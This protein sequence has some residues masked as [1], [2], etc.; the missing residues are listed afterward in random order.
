MGVDADET[1]LTCPAYPLSWA[2]SKSAPARG[3]KLE[4]W[5]RGTRGWSNVHCRHHIQDVLHI[6]NKSAS[7]KGCHTAT[8]APLCSRTANRAPPPPREQLAAQVQQKTHRQGEGN[9]SKSGPTRNGKLKLWC[10]CAFHTVSLV[11]RA[12]QFYAHCSLYSTVAQ[13][14]LLYPIAALP[15]LF[16]PCPFVYRL[17]VPF[18]CTPSLLRRDF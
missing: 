10:R 4:L 6:C 7:P 18:R 1:H 16:L 2:P 13:L 3:R 12:L 11:M 5:H 17:T 8:L 15:L 14:I 9:R